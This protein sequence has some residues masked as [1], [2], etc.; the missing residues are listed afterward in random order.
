MGDGVR[1]AD[2]VLPLS[3]QSRNPAGRKTEDSPMKM[4]CHLDCLK[5]L[6]NAMF[7]SQDFVFSY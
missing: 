5:M 2:S 7:Q 6:T 4:N 3:L 1:H